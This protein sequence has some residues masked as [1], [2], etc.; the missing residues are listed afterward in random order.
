MTRTTRMTRK[1]KQTTIRIHRGVAAK[2]NP[3]PYAEEVKLELTIGK[4]GTEMDQT[5]L[6]SIKAENDNKL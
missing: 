4:F 2:T 1:T 6:W 3:K 5:L